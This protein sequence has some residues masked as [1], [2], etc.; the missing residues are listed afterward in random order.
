M[1]F[2]E[3]ARPRNSTAR[4]NAATSILVSIKLAGDSGSARFQWALEFR[5]GIEAQCL[6]RSDA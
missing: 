6:V 3:S 4:V 2:Q 1:H 5:F